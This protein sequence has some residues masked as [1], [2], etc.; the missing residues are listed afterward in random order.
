MRGNPVN[1]K[2]EAT[3]DQWRIS[4]MCFEPAI[5]AEMTLPDKVQLCD[6]TLREG[7]QLPG[8]S[9]TRDQV[10]KIADK[11]VEAGVSMVQMHHDDPG[12]MLA[13]KKRHPHV[14]IDALVHP[15]AVLSPE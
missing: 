5:R 12:E 11:L 3:T 10:M 13:V 2:L 4:Q 14:L 15:T 9:L 6:I 8:V 1:D 7:R